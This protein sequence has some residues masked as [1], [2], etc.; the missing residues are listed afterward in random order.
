MKNFLK[1]SFAAL[2]S[3]LLFS[4]TKNEDMAVLTSTTPSSL[5]S[6]KSA[7]V[8][9]KDNAANEAV[10]FSWTNPSANTKIAY[11][12]QLQLAV[13][14]TNFANPKNVDLGKDVNK[15]S[16]N[17]QDFN[18]IM[19]GLGLPL[20]GSAT[21]VEARVKSTVYSL[22]GSATELPAPVYSSVLKLTVTPYALVSYLYAPGAYQGWNPPTANTLTSATSNGI[23]IGYINF[24]D[25]NSEFKITPLRN[26]D[27]SY[28][29]TGGNN[30]T[31]NGGDNLKAPNA[32]TQKL[33][34]DL[35][36]MTYT[37][38]PYSW[39]I[40]GSATPNGWNDPD[41]NMVWNDTTGMW[42]ITIAL[43][44]GDI[45][46][47]LNDGW[48]TN[49]GDD[50]NNGSLEPGGANIPITDPGTYKIS[51]DFVNQTWTKTKL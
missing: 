38:A 41:T 16:Y 33:T 27:N 14:G 7:I 42:E 48:D 21:D 29:S 19:L 10:A 24:T 47:R 12:N 39:G 28:G 9:S 51:C 26:W 13:K 43:V 17:V 49:F 32:G 4:C 6:S 30:I 34:V 46:F 1:L 8:L 11:N 20:D 18:A 36:A 2:I 5:T 25:P 40:I 50:G 45:K 3:F 31:Y 37:L 22:D 23:Y 35:N 15:I 44:A